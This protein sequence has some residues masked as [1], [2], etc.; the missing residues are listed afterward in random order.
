MILFG[1]KDKLLGTY[2][3][4]N[5]VCRE[6]NKRG[7]IVS[8]FQIYFHILRIPV[9]PTSRKVASQCYHCRHVDVKKNFSHQQLEKA[10]ELSTAFKTPFWTMT[11]V[12]IMFI[13]LVGKIVYKL[14]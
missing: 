14:I 3:I 7:G 11:G 2:E 5:E 9:F 12:L 10:N 1:R 8:I 6:C 4:P 13:L